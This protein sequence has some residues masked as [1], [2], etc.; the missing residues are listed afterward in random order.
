MSNKP[1]YDRH[2]H[3]AYRVTTAL[4]LGKDWHVLSLSTHW[5]ERYEHAREK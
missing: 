5:H 1:I 2:K 3:A 4:L